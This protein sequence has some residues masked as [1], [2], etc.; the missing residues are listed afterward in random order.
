MNRWVT[1]CGAAVMATTLGWVPTSQAMQMELTR[2]ELCRISDAVVVGEVTDIDTL[3]AATAEGGL[4]RHAFLSIDTTLK[5]A[6]S[7]GAV[8]VLPGG[9]LGDYVHWVE[10]VPELQKGTRYA[11]FLE[12]TEGGFVVIGGEEGAIV[13]ATEKSWKG[14]TVDH[15]RATLEGCHD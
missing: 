3:W 7:T 2:A 13:M 14:E 5:G 1:L 8:L 6:R 12:K 4:E 9:V 10:D 15:V 11:L